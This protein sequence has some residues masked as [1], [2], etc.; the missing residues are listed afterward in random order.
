MIDFYFALTLY[1]LIKFMI[2]E[3]IGEQFSRGDV[4][5][6]FSNITASANK[7]QG[8]CLSINGRL[9]ELTVEDFQGN[10]RS[11]LVEEYV[12]NKPGK[13]YIFYL[14]CKTVKH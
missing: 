11:K 1:V 14:F 6:Y 5:F 3:F 12:A 4:T 7:A 10:F 8:L 13:K 2:S 9:A